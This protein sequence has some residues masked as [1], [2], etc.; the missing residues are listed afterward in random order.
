MHR[1][2]GGGRGGDG[3][4]QDD[5]A[6]APAVLRLRNKFMLGGAPCQPLAGLT[7]YAQLVDSNRGGTG[8]ALAK[9]V[10]DFGTF[11]SSLSRDELGGAQSSM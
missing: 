3:R 4:H 8:G 5:S 1:G 10:T 9:G 6:T 7:V 11:R 2:E